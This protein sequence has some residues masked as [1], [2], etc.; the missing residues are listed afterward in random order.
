MSRRSLLKGGGAALAGLSALQV[1]G[2]AHGSGGRPDEVLV[3]WL[4][5]SRAPEGL[6]QIDW[7]SWSPG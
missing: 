6:L 2:P 7:R 1:A 4:D 5:L 3:P